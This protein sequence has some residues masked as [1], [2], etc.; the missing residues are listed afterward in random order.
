MNGFLITT[1]EIYRVGS[2]SAAEALIAAAKEDN[3]YMLTKYNCEHKVKTQKGEI[4]DE[5]YRVTLVKKFNEE[6]EPEVIVN[7]NY[8]VK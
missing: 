3:N 5:W 2:E 4:I 1:S 8:E 6:K 7:I